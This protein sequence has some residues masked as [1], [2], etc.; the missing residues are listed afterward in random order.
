MPVKP[1]Y[2]VKVLAET[3]RIDNSAVIIDSEV[4]RWTEVGARTTIV[5]SV[6]GDYSYVVHDCHIIYTDIGKFCSIAAFS[7]INPG[8]HP[9]HRAA[10][11][12]FSYRSRQFCLGED[13]AD[14]FQWRR[15]HPVNLGHDVWLG[16][17][18]IVLPGVSIGTGSA[19][20]AGSVVTQ[21]VLP[22]TVVAG[23]PAKPIRERFPK[24]IQDALLRIAWWNW[25]HEQIRSALRDF[26]RLD[27]TAF[28]K[29]YDPV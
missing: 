11:H 4:G 7:R 29:K 27:A 2:K 25:T 9:L 1:R 3:P 19:V 23:T 8:N 10:L 14:F 5:E 26:R 22:F 13:D 12:H 15:S 16:H 24:D 28:S 6:I 20:G 17:G 18:V 21:D